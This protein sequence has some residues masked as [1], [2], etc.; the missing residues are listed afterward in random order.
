MS[1]V[2]EE[3][4]RIVSTVI[5]GRLGHGGTQLLGNS[6]CAAVLANNAPG[7]LQGGFPSDGICS[8]DF[9]SYAGVPVRSATGR[10][11]GMICVMDRHK[12]VFSE[13]E[14][15]LIEIFERYVSYEIQR[16]RM[17]AQ[18][19]QM[20][21]I[22]LL[23]QMAAGVA[24]EVRN[25][26]NAI[27]SISEAFFQEI[28]YNAEHAPFLDHIRTQV[29]RLSRL[30][31][32]L[33][34]LGKP[35]KMSDLKLER[36]PI[37]YAAAKSLWTQFPLSARHN[38]RLVLPE[39]E[40]GLT[41]MAESSRLQQ[42][43]LNLFENA[44]QQSAE[45]S[46]IRVVIS[47]NRKTTAKICIVDSGRG[48]PDDVIGRVFEPFFTTRKGGYGLGLS[49]VK[50]TIEAHGGN[51]TIRNNRPLP[52]STVEITLPLAMEGQT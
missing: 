37:V 38:V 32:S 30:M 44:V 28:G 35:L 29:R 7:Q 15:R 25:P 40:K 23:G 9:R 33:L 6:P 5:D 20:D 17:E 18:L 34:D 21:K 3:M 22:K 36:L 47:S 14:M 49:I 51:V 19:R 24:H 43:L 31:E 12:R 39:G 45:E 1:H 11:E 41:V 27:L 8:R 52:G 10:A 42:V 50:N 46:E 2:E 4:I 16:E 13:D 26:L 48:I